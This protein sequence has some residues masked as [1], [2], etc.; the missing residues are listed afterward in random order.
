MSRKNDATTQMP[1]LAL[2]FF[3]PTPIIFIKI[4][5]S[6]DFCFFLSRKRKQN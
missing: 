3:W 1:S 4:I 6:L 5:C 2:H